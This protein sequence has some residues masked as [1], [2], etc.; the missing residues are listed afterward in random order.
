MRAI[1][2]H[3]AFRALWVLVPLLGS[4]MLCAQDTAAAVTAVY[5]R[6]RTASGNGD[7]PGLSGIAT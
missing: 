1:L 7:V 2:R 6:Y 4:R 3:S 5:E